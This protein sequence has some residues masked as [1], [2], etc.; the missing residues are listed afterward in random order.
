MKNKKDFFVSHDN[1]LDPYLIKQIDEHVVQRQN[2]T[3][4]LRKWK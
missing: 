2:V 4:T 3:L 1:F